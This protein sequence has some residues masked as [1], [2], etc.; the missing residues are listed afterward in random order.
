[1][2]DAYIVSN[3][4]ESLG[5]SDE[6]FVKILPLVK[7]LQGDRRGFLERRHEILQELRRQLESG[8][9]TESRVGELLHDLKTVDNDEPAS[10]RKDMDAI[11]A[12]LST[13]Q[14]A[15]LRLLQ[16]QV[17]QKIRE[18]MNRVRAGGQAGRRRDGPNPK[19]L[20]EP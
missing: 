12:Q 18:L 10:V 7:R 11:D 9:A 16:F 14:Q 2:I 15:K 1:M 3:L 13:V 20:P 8:K 19:E 17:E 4:Q 6:Q 5:L